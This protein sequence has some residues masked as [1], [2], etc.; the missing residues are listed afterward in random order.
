MYPMLELLICLLKSIALSSRHQLSL[1]A[2]QVF[3]L[4][5]PLIMELLLGSQSPLANSVVVDPPF[6]RPGIVQDVVA[7]LADPYD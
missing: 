2:K 1:P 7:L 4:L 5:A 3:I 6:A